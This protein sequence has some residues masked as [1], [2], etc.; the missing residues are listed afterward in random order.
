MYV[1]SERSGDSEQAGE[2]QGGRK[3]KTLPSGVSSKNNK[4]IPLV[5]T[6]VNIPEGVYGVIS[7]RR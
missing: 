7:L 2:W 3:I 6:L 1:G 4:Y 5:N